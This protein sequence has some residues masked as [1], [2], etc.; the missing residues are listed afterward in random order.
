MLNTCTGSRHMRHD[1]IV[2]VG[3]FCPACEATQKLWDANAK[4]QE[5]DE[6]IADLRSRLQREAVMDA[7]RG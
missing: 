3:E 4:L 1:E 6:I 5:L 7:N 2:H